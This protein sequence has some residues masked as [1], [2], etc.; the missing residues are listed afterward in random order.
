[1]TEALR[2]LDDAELFDWLRLARSDNVGPRTFATLLRKYGSARRAIAELPGLV[3]RGGSRPVELA[4]PGVVE[5]ELEAVRRGGLTVLPSCDPRYPALL[6]AI[7]SSPPVLLVLGEADVLARP[8]AAIVG[9]RNASAAG[10]VMTE[11]FARGLGEAGYVVVSGLARGIDAR[12]HQAALATG[13]VAVLAGGHTKI[14][15]SEHAGLAARIA[16]TGGAIVSE[17]PV[18]W[19]P[20]GRD[21]PRR[22]RI[23]SGL[24]LGLVVVEAAQRSGS[25]ITARFASEQGRLVFA[26]PGNPLDPRAE[27]TNALIREGATLC[28]SADHILDDLA[29]LQRSGPAPFALRERPAADGFPWDETDT[30]EPGDP[31]PS[32][33]PLVVAGEED[34][35]SVAPPRQR[36][37]DLL[38]TAPVAIDD[39]IRLAGLPAGEVHAMLLDL[40]LDG[41]VQVSGG[42]AWRTGPDA[43]SLGATSRPDLNAEGPQE[44]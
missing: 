32:A 42:A 4:A 37:L 35:A 1:M 16:D 26:M 8:M 23:V 9:S 2:R 12:A 33:S 18:S 15:P 7:D 19:D 40:E 29:P 17:M 3:R 14:Y 13:T 21:F 5:R 30:L 39:L 36:V 24:A 27:G 41:A 34:D 31:A 38:G 43:P 6:R 11:R 25:L 20:R 10:L 28:A 22:N 44:P